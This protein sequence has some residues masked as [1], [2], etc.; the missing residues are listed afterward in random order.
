MGMMNKTTL[1]FAG[2]DIG[3]S[4]VKSVLV[5]GQG[6]QVGTLVEVPSR[7]MAGYQ[8]EASVPTYNQIDLTPCPL[9]SSPP[10]HKQ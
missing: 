6:A 8:A 2:L 3:G 10:Q 5:N 1:Y 9:G 7:V 4:T